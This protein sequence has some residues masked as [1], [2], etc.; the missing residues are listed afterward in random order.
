MKKLLNALF[1]FGIILIDIDVCLK[2]SHFSLSF[3]Q[4]KYKPK[5]SLFMICY[6]RDHWYMDVFYCEVLYKSKWINLKHLWYKQ[7]WINID[8]E[9]Q[10]HFKEYI[11]F[12]MEN[13]ESSY[14]NKMPKD[15]DDYEWLTSLSSIKIIWVPRWKLIQEKILTLVKK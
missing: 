12:I 8:H 3:L 11:P 14:Y 5:T 9:V 4:K 7:Y 10:L 1:D 6:I 2:V 15:R 13:I